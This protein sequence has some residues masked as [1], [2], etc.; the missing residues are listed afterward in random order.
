[1]AFGRVKR[2]AVDALT[3]VVRKEPKWVFA[4]NELGI[5]YRKLN[6]YK[7]AINNFKK[8]ID[9]DPNF[10]SAIYNL[11]EAEFRNGNLSGAK[12]AYQKL[13]KMGQKNL[14]GQLELISMGAVKK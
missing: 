7:D 12:Q 9:K 10:V 11:G 4:L 14:A 5:A 3:K 6:N 2:G 13:V 8:A 1:M